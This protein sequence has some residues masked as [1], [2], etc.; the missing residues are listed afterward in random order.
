LYGDGIG[1]GDARRA[2]AGGAGYRAAGGG[3]GDRAA[4]ARPAALRPDRETH[5]RI[6]SS[7][8][9]ALAGFGTRNTYSD[10]LSDTR[11]IGAARRWIKAEFDRISAACGGCLEVYY[12][13]S[14]VQGRPQGA[15]G[16]SR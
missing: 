15:D 12:Q 5:R 7:G 16:R 6:G 10:T 2:R 3:G 1:H 4:G 8:H 11:G 9:P 13:S 14:I